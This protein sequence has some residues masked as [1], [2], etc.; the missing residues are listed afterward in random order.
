MCNALCNYDWCEGVR[1]GKLAQ[2][3]PHLIAFRHLNTYRGETPLTSE[4]GPHTDSTD[5]LI[6]LNILDKQIPIL[7]RLCKPVRSKKASVPMGSIVG[8]QLVNWYYGLLEAIP[9]PSFNSSALDG[10]LFHSGLSLPTDGIPGP[11]CHW[12]LPLDS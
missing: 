5:C 9:L 3:S 12:C 10:R 7:V 1:M 4:M 2:L 11:L 8:A 6:H